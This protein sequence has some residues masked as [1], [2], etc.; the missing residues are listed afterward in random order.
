MVINN[1][2]SVGTSSLAELL[3]SKH[4]VGP[5]DVSVGTSVGT[6][7][8][9]SVGVSPEL[10]DDDPLDDGPTVGV[11]VGPLVIVRNLFN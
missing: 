5:A 1:S 6:P 4:V 11:P 10:D 2:P 7:V 9:V 8:G 3:T